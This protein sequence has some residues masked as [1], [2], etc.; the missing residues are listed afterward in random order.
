M[1]V[2]CPFYSKSETNRIVCEGFVGDTN[3][4]I[5]FKKDSDRKEWRSWYCADDPTKCPLYQKLSEFK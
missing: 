4:H 2:T 5:Q 1:H 3:L